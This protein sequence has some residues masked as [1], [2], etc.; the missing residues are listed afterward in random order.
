MSARV[1]L[2]KWLVL[3]GG[4]LA[5]AMVWLWPRPALPE[6]VAVEAHPLSLGPASRPALTV[7]SWWGCPHCQ[8]AWERYGERWV[9]RA[10][11]GEMRLVLRPLARGKAEGLASALLYCA[12]AEA[13]WAM[14][15]RLFEAARQGE[16]RLRAE[17][18]PLLPCAASA[19]TLRQTAADLEAARR[20]AVA[21]TPTLFEAGRRVEQGR[22]EEVMARWAALPPEAGLQEQASPARREEGR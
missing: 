11:A 14:V 15:G 3:G 7:F 17:F 22:M 5:A 4:L 9:A 1:P 18:A 21:Y 10:K 6:G 2:H 19:A 8:R 16:D 13:R 20:W 12:P